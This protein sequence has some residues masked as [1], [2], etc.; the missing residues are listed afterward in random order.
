MYYEVKILTAPFLL[1]V[2]SFLTL[3]YPD[4]DSLALHD[5]KYLRKTLNEVWSV[6]YCFNTEFKEDLIKHGVFTPKFTSKLM[7][8]VKSENSSKAQVNWLG[9]IVNLDDLTCVFNYRLLTPSSISL[10]N[11]HKVE[12]S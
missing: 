4:N 3:M 8:K 7:T 11:K 10:M 5:R 12:T 2:N 9:E 6:G 1:K